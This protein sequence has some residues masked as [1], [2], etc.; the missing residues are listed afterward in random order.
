MSMDYRWTC[1]DI[2]DY[3][4]ICIDD[5]RLIISGWKAHGNPC[6]ICKNIVHKFT[7]IAD[8]YPWIIHGYPYPWIICGCPFTFHRFHGS[9]DMAPGHL[10][11]LWEWNKIWNCQNGVRCLTWSLSSHLVM[12]YELKIK[13]QISVWIEYLLLVIHGSGSWLI[14]KGVDPATRPGDAPPGPGPGHEPWASRY[15]PRTTGS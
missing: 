14:V 12:N 4:S 5:P 3:L 13:R 15:E 9:M 1:K 11:L 7:K 6:A 8:G 10:Y 2:V